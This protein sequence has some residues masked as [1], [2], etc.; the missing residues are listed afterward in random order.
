MVYY[1]SIMY[2]AVCRVNETLN[3]TLQIRKERY[4]PSQAETSTTNEA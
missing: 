4:L 2:M 3:E 1:I